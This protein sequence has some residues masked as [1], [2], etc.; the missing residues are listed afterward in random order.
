MLLICF[1]K[2]R[3]KRAETRMRE[4]VRAG[5]IMESVCRAAVFPGLMRCGSE[6]VLYYLASCCT[7]TSPDSR[8]RLGK[9]SV[10]AR[11]PQP[12]RL[13]PCAPRSKGG[14]AWNRLMSKMGR[15]PWAF[16]RAAEKSSRAGRATRNI[17][18]TSR[19]VWRQ[20]SYF[21]CMVTAQR[22]AKPGE[23]R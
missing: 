22:V 19:F 5:D 13:E 11:T 12:A 1:T 3:R 9:K 21:N 2:R 10:A 18:A 23:N 17:A 16:R 15:L 20:S 4:R 14:L 6:E 7:G 8:R